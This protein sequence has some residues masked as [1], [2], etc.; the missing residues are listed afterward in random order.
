MTSREIIIRLL[1]AYNAMVFML[2]VATC[3]EFI[4]MLY[5][6]KMLYPVLSSVIVAIGVIIFI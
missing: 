3:G 6:H 2:T 1:I 5:K 4:E